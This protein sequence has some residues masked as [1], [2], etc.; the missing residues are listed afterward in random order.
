MIVHKTFDCRRTLPAQ[1]DPCVPSHV[2]HEKGL[3][4]TSISIVRCT[5]WFPSE[6]F[7]STLRKLLKSRRG[8]VA[9]GSSMDL[10]GVSDLPGVAR[11][12]GVQRRPHTGCP[13][14]D[15]R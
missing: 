6:H 10:F 8:W 7:I 13:V 1:Y 9:I 12:L 4:G 14:T 3:L 5:M 15:M 11:T 2:D